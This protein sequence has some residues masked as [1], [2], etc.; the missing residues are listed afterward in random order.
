M[1]FKTN[2]SLFEFVQCGI[3]K[4]QDSDGHVLKMDR[5][6]VLFLYIKIELE[7][8]RCPFH[9]PFPPIDKEK[10]YNFDCTI[11]RITWDDGVARFLEIPTA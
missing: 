4:S 1:Q 2:Y 6:N 8:W 5:R 3:S 7:P 9:S 11:V 10:L